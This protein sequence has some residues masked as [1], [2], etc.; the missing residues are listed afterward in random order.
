MTSIKATCGT[1]AP[2]ATNASAA[3][4]W[5]ASSRVTG[6][7][8]TF[9][10]AAR[11][12]L[13]RVGDKIGL[14]LAKR[15]ALGWL[16]E[17]RCMQIGGGES[18]DSSDQDSFA[19]LIPFKRGARTDTKLPANDR[20]DRDLTLDRQPRVRDCHVSHC[21]GTRAASSVRCGLAAVGRTLHDLL[22]AAIGWHRTQGSEARACKSP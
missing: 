20:R 12:A 6:R 18:A 4:T 13:L 22:G 14:Q 21:R 19:V 10:L 5:W 1:H 15:A 7:T 2:R 17:D 16:R 9:V 8:R 3:A 11:M